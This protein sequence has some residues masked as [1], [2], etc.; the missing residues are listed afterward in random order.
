MPEKE[1]YIVKICVGYKVWVEV[2]KF[3]TTS[4][5]QKYKNQNWGSP[6][7]KTKEKNPNYLKVWFLECFVLCTC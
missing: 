6:Q 5:G 7:K 3:K 4:E 1:K 2:K